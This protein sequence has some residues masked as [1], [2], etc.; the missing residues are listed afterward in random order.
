ML[1]DREQ[2]TQHN[3]RLSSLETRLEEALA[4]EKQRDEKLEHIEQLLLKLTANMPAPAA[5]PQPAPPSAPK[6][7]P[8]WAGIGDPTRP[9]TGMAYSGEPSPCETVANGQVWSKKHADGSVSIPGMPFGMRYGEDG[10]PIRPDGHEPT[11]LGAGHDR[12]HLMDV[13]LVEAAF[14]E[15]SNVIHKKE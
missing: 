7:I 1:T 9:N 11:P 4:R 14:D 3:S 2:L 13:K 6:P 15:N 10:K 8:G 5:P 12:R